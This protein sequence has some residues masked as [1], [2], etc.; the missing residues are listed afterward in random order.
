MTQELNDSL[1]TSEILWNLD[2]LY[3]GIDDLAIKTDCDWLRKE[4]AAV[5]G[6][7]RQT[8]NPLAGG[9]A[10]PGFAS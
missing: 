2:D 4:A 5:A 10:W 6:I 3:T 1:G 9:D 7:C 8:G